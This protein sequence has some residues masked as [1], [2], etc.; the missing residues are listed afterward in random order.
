MTRRA[1]QPGPS[2]RA[3]E[4]SPSECRE[5]SLPR[6]ILDRSRRTSTSSGSDY[7]R[8]IGRP[9]EEGRSHNDPRSG[10][11]S[12]DDSLSERPLAVKSSVI[13]KRPAPHWSNL[14]LAM[15]SSAVI[16]AGPSAH[17]DAVLAELKQPSHL[18]SK[19][20]ACGVFVSARF[21]AADFATRAASTMHDPVIA[22]STKAVFAKWSECGS[23]FFSTEEEQVRSLCSSDEEDG[24]QSHSQASENRIAR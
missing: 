13:V 14:Q 3:K 20:V 18:L 11:T 7:V 10:S 1:G 16:A 24:Q 4:R 23:S 8:A 6:Q 12:S 15:A 2:M 21:V 22:V 9:R 19:D 17:I 5:A